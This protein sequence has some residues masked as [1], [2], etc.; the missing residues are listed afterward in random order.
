MVLPEK[1]IFAIMGSSGAGKSTLLS[2]IA[3][4]EKPS[5]GSISIGG[6]D[7]ERLNPKQ[8]AVFR[9]RYLG[10][11]FQHYNLLEEFDVLF[12][13]A[14]PLLLKGEDKTQAYEKAKTYLKEI[15]LEDKGEQEA[16]ILSGGEK[17]RVALA[18]TLISSPKILL[19]D[20]PTGALDE[21]NA[22]RV[23]SLLKEEGKRRLVLVVTHDRQL[24]EAYCE[25]IFELKNGVLQGKLTQKEEILPKLEK[26]KAPSS[27]ASLT[28]LKRNLVEDAKGN[29]L[30]FGV[31]TLSFLLCFMAAGV[32][33]G[34][35]S[36]VLEARYDYLECASATFGA[37][38]TIE[39]SNS[40]V[41]LSRAYR[42]DIEVARSVFSSLD[43]VSIE[44][45]FSYFFPLSGTLECNE[46][47]Y[48]P[49][50]LVPIFDLS[51]KG[52][53]SSFLISGHYP[54]ADDLSSCL[55]NLA[56]LKET[57]LSI[58]DEVTLAS[59]STYTEG[60]LTYEFEATFPFLIAGSVK[61]FDFLS[62]PK[63]F[64]SY[65]GL[66]SFM[67]EEVLPEGFSSA[68]LLEVVED[69]AGDAPTSGY[70]YRVFCHSKE[71]L[72]GFWAL[73][74]EIGEE[75]SFTVD[76]FPL[77]AVSSYSSIFLTMLSLSPL[78]LAVAF[79]TSFF[80]IFALTYAH[81]QKRKKEGAILSSLGAPLSQIATPYFI[82]AFLPVLGGMVV[83]LMALSLSINALNSILL[84][85]LGLS[86]LCLNPF[87]SL[88][89]VPY[90]IPLV[91]FLLTLLISLVGTL[92]GIRP[93]YK[94]RI[95]EELRDE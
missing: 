22:K 6:I 24:A 78:F 43:E 7:L 30:S 71:A 93:L 69:S 34:A 60:Y 5:G 62:T 3:G 18:R 91:S 47:T 54:R 75:E 80:V 33:L 70:C 55:V 89:G 2:L 77:M 31:S 28:L 42:P 48:G 63:L 23:M 51:L 4:L 57:G 53:G 19:S 45:D 16:R 87:G 14:L 74:E 36:S 88:F 35:P 49:I 67:A 8:A 64:Y 59:S 68:N 46:E 81:Y 11:L 92:L 86:S 66:R 15:G 1:G 40:P 65:S 56:F 94:G 50:S 9:G 58:G 20:E 29:L 61:E 37:K 26:A 27:F 90:F 52:V 41:S 13:V 82:E 76:C 10:M 38:E 73:L 79:L 72:L 17:Q 85:V 32:A 44:P 25:K 84:R 12:N 95:Y 39:I 83:S 21:E